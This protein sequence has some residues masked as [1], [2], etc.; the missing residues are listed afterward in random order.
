[1]TVRPRFHFS[2]LN[3]NDIERKY[4]TIFRFSIGIIIHEAQNSFESYRK[5]RENK[6]CP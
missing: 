6:T 3:S 4:I 5:Y 2:E 1:M